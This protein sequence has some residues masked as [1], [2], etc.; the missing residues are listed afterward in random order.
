MENNFQKQEE[1]MLEQFRIEELEQRLEMKLD[2]SPSGAQ[3]GVT[4]G[5]SYVP[6]YP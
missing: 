2:W 4:D 3:I 1:Q 5:N 6:I